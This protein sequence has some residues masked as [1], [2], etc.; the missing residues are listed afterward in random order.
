MCVIL[1]SLQKYVPCKTTQEMVLLPACLEEE[2]A[3][4]STNHF[5]KILLGVDQ[6]TCARVRGAQIIRHNHDTGK[7]RLQGFF[8]V[9]EDWHSK[10]SA[11]GKYLFCFATL[12]IHIRANVHTGHLDKAIQERYCNGEGHTA[13]DEKP[14][15]SS[16]LHPSVPPHPTKNVN[17]CKDFLEVVTIARIVGAV[18]QYFQMHAIDDTP[19]TTFLPEE[20]SQ[21]TSEVQQAILLNT[22]ED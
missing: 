6:L 17:A 14:P 13:T 10:L 21:M 3:A 5:N 8:P 16:I 20:I 7:K 11:L 9:V 1:E 18:M 19:S 12:Q 2:Q 4:V 15:P 22:L